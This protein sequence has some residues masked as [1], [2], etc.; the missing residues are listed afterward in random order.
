MILYKPTAYAIHS[1]TGIQKLRS[2][3]KC[4]IKLSEIS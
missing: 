4:I 1:N 3:T 2:Q